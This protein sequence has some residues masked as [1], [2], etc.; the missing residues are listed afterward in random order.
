MKLSASGRQRRASW[1]VDKRQKGI[2]RWVVGRKNWVSEP[3]VGKPDPGK[4]EA[5]RLD[6]GRTVRY[7]ELLRANCMS[8]H[9][10]DVWEGT[11][12]WVV[13]LLVSKAS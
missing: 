13:K 7:Y 6:E 12:S 5:E 11:W 4:E 3:G 2:K 10:Q 8:P 1:G 9:A